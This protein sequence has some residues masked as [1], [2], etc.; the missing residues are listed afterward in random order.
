MLMRLHP[1][2][3]LGALV[4]AGTASAQSFNIDVASIAGSP[5][6]GYGAAAAQPGHWN[7][8]TGGPPYAATLNNLSNFPT[9][10]TTSVTAVGNGLGDFSFNN[11][12]TFGDDEFLM[13]DCQ[14][15]GNGTSVPPSETTWTFSGLNPVN[16]EI[17]V[18]AWAPDSAAFV[19]HV[20]E[21][22]SG[23]V[24]IVGG[25]W[26]GG[27]L[28]GVTHARINTC[29]TGGQVQIC[30]N[31]GGVGGN[32]SSVNGFQFRE[33]GGSCGAGQPICF[34][35]GSGGLCGCGNTGAAG[36]GCGNS[37]G[38]GAVMTAAGVPS[39][40]SDSLEFITTQIPNSPGLTFQALNA[41]AS[42]PTFGDGIRCCGGSVVRII[43][44]LAAGNCAST[45]QPSGC[46]SQ[47]GGLG[48]LISQHPG[49]A[50]LQAGDT[51]CYQHWYRDP[52]AGNPC[53]LNF[54]NLSNGFSVTWGP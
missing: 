48:G 33:T 42:P 12:S 2:Y 31:S 47:I 16:Y 37:T 18:Y 44:V 9:S 34:G 8:L 26:P 20:S 17:Y 11:A 28:E 1:S 46:G 24:T 50:G 53:Q 4:L 41:I 54:F 22:G 43:T 14:D 38:A 30:V 49:N 32:F 6:S 35:D 5:S 7:V 23:L 21:C 19:S 25:A 29:A 3:A 51:R 39:L 10:V 13:D 27:F 40:T 36:Q 15:I 52:G 45:N